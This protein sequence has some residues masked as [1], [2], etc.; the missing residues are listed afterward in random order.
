MER[1]DEEDATGDLG[2]NAILLAAVE[3]ILLGSILPAGEPYVHWVST[4]VGCV[5]RYLVIYLQSC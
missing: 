2:L 4:I 3:G 5:L 1:N